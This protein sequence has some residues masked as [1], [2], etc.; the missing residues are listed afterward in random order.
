MILT[1]DN[2]TGL[3]ENVRQIEFVG[4]QCIFDDKKPSDTF[5]RLGD[6]KNKS[7]NNVFFSFFEKDKDKKLAKN[8]DDLVISIS[9]SKNDKG[10]DVYQAQTGNYI[11]KFKH[12]GVDID[13]GSRF[14]V[15]FLKRMLNFANDVYL[16]DVSIVGEET[17]NKKID[18]SRFIVYYLFVQSLEKAYLLGLPKAYRSVKH[19]EAML[20]GR[21]SINAFIK[22]D[23]PFQGKI[24]SVA[25][26]QQEIQEIIDVLHK[27]I[28][29]VSKNDKGF[30]KNISH[31]TPHLRQM[32]SNSLVSNETIKNAMN[33]KAL[34]NPIFTP[35]KKVLRYAKYIINANN[36]EEKKDAKEQSF[37]FLVNVAELF[38]IYVTKLLQKE[39]ADWSVESPKHELYANQFYARK[40]IPDIVMKRGNDVLIFDTKYKKMIMRGS[41]DG[42]WD[43]DRADF[44]QINTYMSYYQNQNYNV[45]GGGL[46]Y[47]MESFDR[48]ICHAND[49]MGKFDSKFI[50]DGIS[51]DAKS[52]KGQILAAEE[53]FIKRIKEIAV[54]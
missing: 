5:I 2:F 42:I 15:K 7:S 25:R 1:V 52:S 28:K 6:Y 22:N 40:I 39:F 51:I 46:L 48:N 14:G 8:A 11:G 44:F 12:N 4:Y 34:Q 38:E 43:V 17:K 26:E 21:I 18:Y 30:L 53:E 47:P 10:E 19:H 50:I 29:I 41:G 35:Y 27:A 36:I 33:S 20:K 37:G 45:V 13:I 49:W 23:T 16:D 54:S 24:S 31:I 32:R 9:K 3:A